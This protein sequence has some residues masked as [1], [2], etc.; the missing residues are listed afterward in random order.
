MNAVFLD[1][2][3]TILVDKGYI[4]IPDDVA[5]LP[6]AAEAEERP[7]FALR[8]GPRPTVRAG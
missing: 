7:R 4:T 3:G 1:R 2:D 6:G 5:L 8:R